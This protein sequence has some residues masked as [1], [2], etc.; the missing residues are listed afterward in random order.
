MAGRADEWTEQAA[1]GARP[2]GSQQTVRKG[3]V[4]SKVSP[5]FG[6][7]VNVAEFGGR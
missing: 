5:F 6:E 7:A 3:H 1:P 4:D 2:Q